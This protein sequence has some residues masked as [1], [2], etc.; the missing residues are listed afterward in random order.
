M[1][2]TLLIKQSKILG[3]LLHCFFQIRGLLH[4]QNFNKYPFPKEGNC[5]ITQEAHR[6]LI[7][8]QGQVFHLPDFMSSGSQS[9]VLER[10]FG[11]NLSNKS[12]HIMKTQFLLFIYY[13]T[14]G[15]DSVLIYSHFR[16]RCRPARVYRIEIKWMEQQA[17]PS[18]SIILSTSPFT[19]S[20]M[21]QYG[22][23]I[24]DHFPR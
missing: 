21:R 11:Q 18:A 13:F 9:I 5:L 10:F 12:S 4:Y 19:I 1:E 15:H 22:I 8:G 24:P 20:L 16:Y 7:C 2:L 6:E 17:H 23:E 14:L 3:L